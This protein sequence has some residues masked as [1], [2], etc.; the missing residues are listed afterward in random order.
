MDLCH[1]SLLVFLPELHLHE[2]GGIFS[3]RESKNKAF[4]VLQYFS[5]GTLCKII[6]YLF[7]WLWG[8]L[9]ESLVAY[10][11]QFYETMHVW[12]QAVSC[13]FTYVVSAKPFVSLNFSQLIYERKLI[14]NFLVINVIYWLYILDLKRVWCIFDN[15]VVIFLYFK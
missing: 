10:A 9:R 12:M 2:M 6:Q 11:P 1:R 14:V 3:L 15:T 13:P 5:M 4:K 7:K 8:K